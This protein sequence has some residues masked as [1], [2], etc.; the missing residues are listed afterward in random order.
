MKNGILP[1]LFLSLLSCM[2]EEEL[3]MKDMGEI[4]GYFIECYCKPGEYYTLNAAKVSPIH[5][6]IDLSDPVNLDVSIKADSIIKLIPTFSPS[7]LGNF[8]HDTKFNQFGLDSLYLSIYTPE[9]EHITA[10]TA[11][12]DPIAIS[13]YSV[14]KVTNSVTISFPI[15][16]NP[17]Q[18]YYIYSV[19]A[20][21][22]GAGDDNLLKK[23][24][25]Y[26]DLSHHTGGVTIERTIKCQEIEEAEAVVILLLRITEECYNYQ[27]SLYEANSANQGSITSPVPLIGNIQ[28]ALGIFTCYTEDYKFVS[29]ENFQ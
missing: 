16:S 11:I 13:S 5:E 7:F 24:T 27:V 12:P 15:S 14:S 29:R 25:S 26:L 8:R 17:M 3:P 4:S 20:R 10:K 18:N 19:Q 21:K 23:E 1:L 9:K 6:I 22:E 2:P 28:G